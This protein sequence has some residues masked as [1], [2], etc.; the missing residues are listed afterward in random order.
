[1][2]SVHGFFCFRFISDGRLTMTTRKEVMDIKGMSEAKV[3]KVLEAAQKLT[4][5]KFLTGLEFLNKRKDVIRLSTGS[6]ALDAL[7]GG[8]VETMAITEVFGEF[9]CGK[10][11]LAHTLCVTCQLPLSEG[12]GAGRACFIDTEGTFRP[13]KIL[14]IAARFGVDPQEALDNIS[15]CRVFNHEQQMELIPIVAAMFA[16]QCYRLLVIDSISATF[17]VDFSGRGELAERQ[18]K[19]GK[20]LSSLTKLA[21]EFNVAVYISNQVISDPSGGMGTFVVD[22]KK[23][24]GGHVMAH[25]S[26]WRIYLRKGRGEVRIAKIYDSPSVAETECSFQLSNGGIVDAKD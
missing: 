12:G 22:P 14:E 3:E 18:Q 4:G 13:E 5:P 11:Q 15:Y 23:P 7:L 24:A 10:T 8:G 19:L 25:A 16:E 26:Q 9:R 20:H 2:E 17:R 21:E 1:M 6:T